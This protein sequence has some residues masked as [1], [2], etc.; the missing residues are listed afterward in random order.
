MTTTTTDDGNDDDDGDERTTTT[1]TNDD[2]DLRLEQARRRHR[3]RAVRHGEDD[4]ARPVDRDEQPPH[5]RG[6]EL[7]VDAAHRVRPDRRLCNLGGWSRRCRRGKAA[8]PVVVAAAAAA[9]GVRIGAVCRS[10][11]VVV[12]HRGV[13]VVAVVGGDEHVVRN[14]ARAVVR[15]RLVVEH[16]KEEDEPAAATRISVSSLCTSSR[17]DAAAR[18]VA[19][20]RVTHPPTWPS[21]KTAMRS[22]GGG[23]YFLVVKTPDPYVTRHY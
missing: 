22:P 9:G 1:T 21:R 19:R 13:V 14:G 12:A 5:R 3:A 8:G 18:A 10:G 17:C 2:G 23:G 11:V 20:A 7:V 15:M 6:H 16:T 4:V